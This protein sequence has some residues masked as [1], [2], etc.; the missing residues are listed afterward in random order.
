MGPEGRTPDP[1]PPTSYGLLHSSDR[2]VER[3]LDCA[4]LSKQ[5]V[6]LSHGRWGSGSRPRRWTME[7]VDDLGNAGLLIVRSGSE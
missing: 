1:N 2:T 5:A 7:R 3:R 6:L 4:A